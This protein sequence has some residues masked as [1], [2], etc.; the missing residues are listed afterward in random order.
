MLL[1][2]KQQPKQKYNPGFQLI[3]FRTSP[4]LLKKK[5][6]SFAELK[7]LQLQKLS[8]WFS[9]DLINEQFELGDLKNPPKGRD[10]SN[11]PRP[12]QPGWGHLQGCAVTIKV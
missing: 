6:I 1:K 7:I 2:K 10:T 8:V 5:K 3:L 12:I 11:Y 9:E 4:M